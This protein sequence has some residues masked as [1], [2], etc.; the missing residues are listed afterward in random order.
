MSDLHLCTCAGCSAKSNTLRPRG[1]QG[2]R[3]LC[4]GSLQARTLERAAMPSS[5][6]PSQPGIEPRP[7]SL[8]ADSLP[9]EPTG[10]PNVCL[11]HLFPIVHG[12]RGE[13][14]KAG[15]KPNIQ[16]TKTI[17]SSSTTSWHIDGENVEA[18]WDFIFLDS[19]IN[20]DGD[21]GHEI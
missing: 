4:P 17:A 8:Q 12:I 3:L 15:W 9:S 1:L 19:K 5:R 13:S 21:C 16:K 11:L 18:M 2:A 10:K 7:P 6:G 20:A 14:E